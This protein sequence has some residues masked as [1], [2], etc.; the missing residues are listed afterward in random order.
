MS[1]VIVTQ[2]NFINS[3]STYSILKAPYNLN[4]SKLESIKMKRKKLN[5][6]CDTSKQSQLPLFQLS[7][8][9]R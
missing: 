5:K 4:G 3:N 1:S 6:V 7:Q 9:K 2:R 8:Q